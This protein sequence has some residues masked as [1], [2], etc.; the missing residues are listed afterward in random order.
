MGGFFFLIQFIVCVY[1]S[2]NVVDYYQHFFSISYLNCFSFSVETALPSIHGQLQLRGFCN[3]PV[4]WQII[5]NNSSSCYKLFLGILV[6]SPGLHQWKEFAH[7]SRSAVIVFFFFTVKNVICLNICGLEA[8]NCIY[9]WDNK[10][11]LDSESTLFSVQ[12]PKIVL[13]TKNFNAEVLPN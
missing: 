6:A 9:N 1:T 7:L 11:T 13:F 12:L 8:T 5:P 10:W 4:V 2:L 3:I